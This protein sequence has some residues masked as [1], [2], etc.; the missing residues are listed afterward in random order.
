[1]I[2]PHPECPMVSVVIIFLNGEKYI[3]EAIDSV[4]AQTY[5][6]WELILVDDGTTDGATAIAKNYAKSYP[7][8]IT[9]TEHPNHE[10]RGMSASRN[11]GVALAAGEYVAFLDAD[12][13]WLPQRLQRH[14]E[15]L[16]RHP[17]AAISMSPTLLWSSWNEDPHASRKPWLTAD[18]L[19]S[20][21][22][23]P[24]QVFQPPELATHYLSVHGLGVP[25][26]CSQTIKR[27]AILAVGGSED[28]FKRLYEDQV[29]L[30]KILL[31][32]PAVA[33]DEVLDYYR[34]HPESACRE[35]G[36]MKGDAAARPI[37]LQ[38]LQDYMIRQSITDPALWQAFRAEMWRFDNPRLWQLTNLPNAL[39]NRWGMGSRRF[40][41][42]LLTPK[43]YH[44]LRRLFG[45]K[46]IEF[47][48]VGHATQH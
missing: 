14:V 6:H 35:E 9:Y 17:A 29:L 12:D 34:Q 30:F 5:E 43:V 48:Q 45:L 38:W 3:G 10:N 23:P 8:K 33:L 11:A 18:I 46:P 42:W 21:Y 13:I 22:L 7:G 20:L 24:N 15:A 32:Y 36:G 40:V 47:R 19:H 4:L 16:Q 44:G 27:E 2:S 25:G 37:F 31:N 41:I 39:I 26:I 28:R 1:M